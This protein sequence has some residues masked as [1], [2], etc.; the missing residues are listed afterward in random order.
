M[1]APRR[2]TVGPIS[3]LPVEPPGQA[4]DLWDQPPSYPYS[5]IRW[6]SPLGSWRGIGQGATSARV[7]RIISSRNGSS[8]CLLKISILVSHCE[9]VYVEAGERNSI[10]SKHYQC[11]RQHW[12]TAINSQCPSIKDLFTSLTTSDW[13]SL[14]RLLSVSDQWPTHKELDGFFAH[15]WFDL[16]RNR[17][18]REIRETGNQLLAR[19]DTDIRHGKHH[20]KT[21]TTT[22]CTQWPDH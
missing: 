6:L 16:E 21:F 11:L 13:M 19:Q 15:F 14:L 2:C 20:I 1:F 9:W 22:E 18:M 4:P 5:S 8:F 12:L 10:A 17:G 3:H 7:S